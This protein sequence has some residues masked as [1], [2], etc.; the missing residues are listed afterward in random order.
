MSEA[1]AVQPNP[2]AISPIHETLSLLFKDGDAIIISS[3][4]THGDFMEKKAFAS[5]DE[6]EGFAEALDQDFAVANIYVNLQQLKPGSLTDKRQDV[7]S[8][9]RFLVDIDR[10]NKKVGGVRV[11]ASEEERDSLRKVAD[12]VTKW[13][14]GILGAHPLLAD[15]GNGFHLCWYLR[16]NAFTDAIAPNEDNKITYKECL[17]AIKQRFDSE[18]VEIDAIL[19]EPEQI[20]RLWGTW[21][22]RDPET[23]GRPH[24]QSAIIAKARGAVSLA[25]LGL[26]ACEYKAPA[27]TLR[28][29]KTMPLRCIR[30]L[31]R[32]RGGNTTATSSCA[33]RS[34]T[35]GR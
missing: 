29:R 19:S 23:E 18:S 2:T 35:A 17:L 10:K 1:Q 4:R 34:T 16:P 3:L 27:K 15:S 26:L 14:S 11:N 28:Q 20:I 5:I 22:R 13:V 30:T 25:H 31:M 6:A 9:V 24:R 21:N 33:R 8:Y 7:A 12:K 32:P